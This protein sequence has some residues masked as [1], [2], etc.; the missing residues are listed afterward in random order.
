MF[1]LMTFKKQQI[2]NAEVVIMHPQ[3]GV[4]TDMRIMV[5][6]PNSTQYKEADRRVKNRNLQ[7]LQKMKGQK[8]LSIEAVEAGQ[9]ELL[10]SVTLGWANVVYAGEP[11]EFTQDNV[12]MLYTQFPFIVEQI[13]EFLGEQRNFLL[14]DTPA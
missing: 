14:S 5:A 2:D 4:A 8:I 10:V 9:L 3:T 12:K 11:L 13:D 1:D 7:A 6:G